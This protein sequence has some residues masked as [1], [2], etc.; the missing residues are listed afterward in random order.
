MKTRDAIEWIKSNGNKLTLI[1]GKWIN[2][3]KD[4]IKKRLS[5]YYTYDEVLSIIDNKTGMYKELTDNWHDFQP[6]VHSHIHG[7]SDGAAIPEREDYYKSLIQRLPFQCQ[8]D[9]SNEEMLCRK[10][11]YLT[12]KSRIERGDRYIRDIRKSIQYQKFIKKSVDEFLKNQRA[13]QDSGI[14]P[15]SI[16]FYKDKTIKDMH[17]LTLLDSAKFSSSLT[18]ELPGYINNSC[19]EFPEKEKESLDKIKDFL[20]QDS[21]LNKWNDDHELSCDC[22]DCREEHE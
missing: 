22:K 7:L 10:C 21:D 11:E 14:Q 1:S 4:K 12:G 17:E 13:L 19:S 20:N 15:L 6:S 18:G 3:A 2:F 5:K 8:Y 16:N 9:E